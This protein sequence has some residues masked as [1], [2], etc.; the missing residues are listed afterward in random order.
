V[1]VV[2]YI[3]TFIAGAALVWFLGKS[4]KAKDIQKDHA[5]MIVTVTVQATSKIDS[6]LNENLVLDQKID[7]LEN[8]QDIL[9]RS[10][11]KDL[12]V[13]NNLNNHKLILD[14]RLQTYDYFSTY[15]D[16]DSA[17]IWII[18]KIHNGHL[19]APARFGN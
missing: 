3:L 5:A 14:E 15:T 16:A 12:S 18:D 17:A 13:E 10:I 6:L 2:S 19:T 8:R 9:R 11:I 4:S 7:S 1:K